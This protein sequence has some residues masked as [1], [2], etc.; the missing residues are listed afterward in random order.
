MYRREISLYKSATALG[1]HRGNLYLEGSRL[2]LAER[3]SKGADKKT[4]SS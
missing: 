2:V 4:K 3:S 1:R